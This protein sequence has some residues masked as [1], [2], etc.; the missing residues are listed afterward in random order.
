MTPQDDDQSSRTQITDVR[1]V[2]LSLLSEKASETDPVLRR[3]V[4]SVD[5]VKVPVAAF[6]ASL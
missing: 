1:R 6:D 2:P 5:A 4:P 3:I